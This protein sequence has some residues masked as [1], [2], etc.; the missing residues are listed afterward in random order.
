[1]RL[2]CDYSDIAYQ[3]TLNSKY[4]IDDICSSDSNNEEWLVEDDNRNVF[5]ILDNEIEIT[6]SF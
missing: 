1:M 3:S 5:E 2:P 4:A 6:D